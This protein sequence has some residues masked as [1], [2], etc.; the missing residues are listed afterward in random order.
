M[1]FLSE[2][3]RKGT[4]VSGRNWELK[5]YFSVDFKKVALMKDESRWRCPSTSGA[6]KSGD[7]EERGFEM[8]ARSN[9]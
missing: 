5:R 8:R 4:D 2:G 3:R 7:M 6:G 9:F 1:R